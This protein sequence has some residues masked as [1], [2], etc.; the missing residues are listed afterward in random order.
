M[1]SW[2]PGEKRHQWSF[3]LLNPALVRPNLLGKVCCQ[4]VEWT[5][6]FFLKRNI[7]ICVC[8]CVV[9][10]LSQ[11]SWSRL[12]L[13]WG[14]RDLPHS[15]LSDS[16]PLLQQRLQH[17]DGTLKRFVCLES[18][19]QPA[20][21]LGSHL[22]R[23]L[24]WKSKAHWAHKASWFKLL[25]ESSCSFPVAVCLQPEAV[26]METQESSVLRPEVLSSIRNAPLCLCFTQQL[27]HTGLG[28]LPRL[29]ASHGIMYT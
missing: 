11:Q 13:S 22:E 18:Y 9:T 4:L 3:W 7:E 1:I 19:S 16:L 10:F 24:W 15:G 14:D 27:P 21:R 28:N 20:W 2:I 8:V 17:M 29:W 6:G 23:Q 12:C 25:R 5:W 26:L